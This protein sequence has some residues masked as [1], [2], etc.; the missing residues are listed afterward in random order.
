MACGTLLATLWT[1]WHLSFPIFLNQCPVLHLFIP[2]EFLFC[3][4]TCWTLKSY[5][6]SSY[7]FLHCL[8]LAAD[9]W[10]VDTNCGLLKLLWSWTDWNGPPRCSVSFNCVETLEPQPIFH[11]L[12]PDSNPIIYV[13][14][15]KKQIFM[16][17]QNMNSGCL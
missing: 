17:L 6:K 5:W 15:I 3:S 11:E 7:N 8:L 16:Y 2:R 13:I 14:Y 12:R 4:A 1:S 10:T 9:Q